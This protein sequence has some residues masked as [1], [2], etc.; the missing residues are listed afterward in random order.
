F[1]VELLSLTGEEGTTLRAT[2]TG[3]G[4]TLL[5]KVLGLNETQ[6][7]SLGLIFRHCEDAGLPLVDLED[8]RAA[9]A[10]LT[11]PGKPQLAAIGGVSTATAGV[12]LRKVSQLGADGGDDFFGEPELDV[13]DLLRTAP[14]G[15]GVISI[16]DLVGVAR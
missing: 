12:I 13:A 2:V 8:L 9:L 4:P 7:S 14:D 15:R 5:A 3:F 11:G 10:Y 1:P 16:L 6:E